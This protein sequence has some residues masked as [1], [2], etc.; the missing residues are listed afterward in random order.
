MS[1]K[2]PAH[3]NAQH[4]LVLLLPDGL[5]DDT[6]RGYMGYLQAMLEAGRASWST[7]SCELPSL[8]RPLYATLI[9]GQ[10]PLDHGIISNAQ[11]G[12][13]VA[14]TLFDCLDE[15][16]LRSAVAAYHWF[17]ELLAGE[18]FEPLRHRHALPGRGVV[19]A[20]WYFEDEYPDSHLL[21]DAEHLRALHQPDFLLV[22]PMG[23]DHA[24]HQHGGESTAY[25]LSARKLDMLLA[26]AVPAWH[27]QG[28][29]VL[30][31]SDHGMHADRMHGGPLREEREVP[32]VWLPHRQESQA[33][34]PLPQR[35]IDV[36]GF[37]VERLLQGRRS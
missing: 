29:D 33:E 12:Q 7:L 15:N 35:Q 6:A 17:Y 4:K 16:G 20:S 1:A 3:P 19:G 5:R 31:T 24:G 36:C 11:P 10:R 9:T 23:P 13:R 32:L 8:S 2:A 28:Y 30:L 34:T 25:A 14:A 27:A 26:H 18:V 37:M 21:A 22:H